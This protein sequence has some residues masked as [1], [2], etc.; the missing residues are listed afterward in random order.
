MARTRHQPSAFDTLC[1]ASCSDSDASSEFS[2]DEIDD[3]LCTGQL[4][5]KDEERFDEISQLSPESSEGPTQV[6]ELMKVVRDLK[7]YLKQWHLS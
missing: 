4:Y 2:G 1:A 7:H 5:Q 6:E 3:E